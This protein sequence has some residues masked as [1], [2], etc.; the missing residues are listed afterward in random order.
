MISDMQT[1]TNMWIE[2]EDTLADTS[3]DDI[4]DF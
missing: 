1:I 2:N 3:L 4:F